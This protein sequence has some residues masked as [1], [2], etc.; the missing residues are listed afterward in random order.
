MRIQDHIP[1][2][3]PRQTVQAAYGALSAVQGEHPG[4]QV[5]AVAVLFKVLAEELK[6][7]VSEVL[8][9]AHRITNADDTYYR[10]EVKALRD[11]VRGEIKR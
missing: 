2:V 6:L 3:E 9:Q 11:Y 8:S 1:F 7:D 4:V 5:A 10:R